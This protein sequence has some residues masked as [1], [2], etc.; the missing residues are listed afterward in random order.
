M[1]WSNSIVSGRS[2]A[3]RGCGGRRRAIVSAL[4]VGATALAAAPP[5]L[6]TTYTPNTTADHA[7]NGCT[8]NDCSLR[9]AVI[10]ANA[11]PGADKIV[12]GAKTYKLALPGTGEN[13][14]ANGDL[15]L[16][17][18]LTIV[19]KGPGQTTVDAGG[20]ATGEGAFELL[21]HAN[22]SI[23]A[24]TERGADVTSTTQQAGILVDTGAKLS[25]TD[26]K[27]I[28]NIDN[29]G[30]SACCNAGIDVTATGVNLRLSHVV[31]AHNTGTTSCDGLTVC[32]GAGNGGSDTL[33]H[34]TVANNSS[35][36]CC[37]GLITGV[38]RAALTDVRVSGN[39]SVGCCTGLLLGSGKATLLRVV[40]NG[41]FGSGC[42]NGFE[43]GGG[44]ASL[45]DVAVT[46]NYGSGC[47][48]GLE[49]GPGRE[50]ITK[51]TI[52]GNHDSTS[53]CT[54]V[55]LGVGKV[56]LIDVTVSG[57]SA[58]GS[59][60]GISTSGAGGT[61]LFM[62]NVTVSGN[63]AGGQGGG[64]WSPFA[65]A[66]VIQNTIIAR[67]TAGSGPDC[68]GT[69]MSKGYNLIGST[70]A[71]TITGTITGNLLGVNPLLGP[72][73]D[74]GGFTETRALKKGSPAVDHGAP[75]KPGSGG[76]A[77]ASSDQRGVKRPQGPRCDIGAYEL[78]FHR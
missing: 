2:T 48:Q 38:G 4:A 51:S 57:N 62:N 31:I 5:A 13:A 39:H 36:G 69:L 70:S 10:A 3:D 72:L 16:K 27:V 25:M 67:N 75:F 64:I 35:T 30:A 9:E 49:N 1:S 33:D 68:Y 59:G 17:G 15:D 29:G 24:L 47:C 26:A 43:G 21:A 78:K 53:N 74:N 77:C 76:T 7:P 37:D 50:T 61:K 40:V 23:A 11:H 18:E 60:G 14:A 22:V 41:N 19:G 45:T 6:A 58:A 63:H 34:V 66:P 52:S 65:P 32:G 20:I 28:D 8:K 54:G 44:P 46:D 71:C 73:H 55:C 12:L 56:R 42:C